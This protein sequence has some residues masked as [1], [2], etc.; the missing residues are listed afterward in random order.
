MQTIGEMSSVAAETKPARRQAQRRRRNGCVDGRDALTGM[1]HHRS[2]LEALARTRGQCRRRNE[3]LSLMLLDLDRFREINELHSHDVGDRVLIQAGVLLRQVCRDGDILARYSW[4]RFAAALPGTTEAQG[5]RI[6][7]RCN[8]VL[9]AEPL[10]LDGATVSVRASVGVAESRA[11]CV[12]SPGDLIQRAER[13]L[14]VAKHNGGHR[15]VAFSAAAPASMSRR[16]LDQA[17]VD[18]VSR[19]IGSMRQ[20]L[21]Q[22]YLESTS[23]LVGAVEAKDPHTRQ[24]SLRVSDFTGELAQRLGLPAAQIESLQTAAALHD[25]GKIGVPDA[26]LQKPGPL[27]RDEF[28]LIRQHPETALQIL[29][30]ARFLNA[31]LPTILHHHERFDGGGYPAGLS[32]ER[33]PFAARILAVADALDAMSSRRSYKEEYT[34]DRIRQELE[35]ES[36]RQW[37]PVVVEA[38]LDWLNEAPGALQDHGERDDPTVT[39]AG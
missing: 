3:P 1:L 20:Q 10:C 8:D 30:H 6:A 16:R 31:E 7:V 2:F 11:G 14:E 5:C 12:E 17:S 22:A 9:A 4:D 24:H 32:G 21:R 29:G 19:W 27:T 23:A 25:V 33:I 35:D 13:A 34:L 39:R 18:T 28:A 37:D 38:A 15:V 36:G 26:I